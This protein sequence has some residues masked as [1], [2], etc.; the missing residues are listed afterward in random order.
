MSPGQLA[1]ALVVGVDRVEALAAGA[2]RAIADSAEGLDSVARRLGGDP[3]DGGWSGRSGDTARGRAADVAAEVRVLSGN[4]LFLADVLRVEGSRLARALIAWADDSEG[5]SPDEEPIDTTEVEDADDELTARLREAAD[6]LAGSVD[7]DTLPC[8]DLS[9]TTGD[10]PW[11]IAELWHSLSPA[12]RERLARDHPELGSAAGL[13][14]ATRDALNRT[15]LRR[16][17]E[18]AGSGSG[19][20]ELAEAA[21]GLTALAAHLEADPRRHLLD[22]HVDGRAVVANADPDTAGRVVTF[23]PGTGASLDSIGRSAERAEAVCE[24]AGPGVPEPGTGGAEPVDAG[25]ESCVAVSWMGYDAPET[26][27]KAG[28]S[29][30]LAREHAGDLRSYSAGL[31]AVE[32]MDGEDAP[33]AAVAYSYGS[34]TLGAAA[35]DPGGLAADRMIHVGSPGASVDSIDE[36][37]ID[38]GGTSRKAET[39]EVVGVTSRWDAVPW[40]SVTGLL[41]AP[42]GTEGFGGLAVDV[43]EPGSGPKSVQD[44]HSQYFDKGTVSLEEIGR[45]VAETE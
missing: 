29:P 17:L 11:K 1:E 18:A 9:A 31:D 14:S 26:I 19:G 7:P 39:N 16:L 34:T 27:P 40:W 24:A 43:T 32:S 23:V 5:R 41:G 30:D 12:E 13:S 4:C 36:Q 38:E 20:E 25:T 37:W 8:L 35:S 2:G 28:V 3:A 10:D 15:R 22:L 44:V 42:P 6:S 45:L 21:P 33:H